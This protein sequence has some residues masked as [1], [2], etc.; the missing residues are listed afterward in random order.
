M[1][2]PT[3]EAPRRTR[4]KRGQG[5]Q[6]REQILDATYELLVETGNA[7]KV[8]TR[9]VAQRVGCSSPAL[10]LHFPDKASL[11]WATCNRQFLRLSELIA[12]AVAGLDDPVEALVAAGRAYVTFGVEHLEEY[13]VMMMVPDMVIWNPPIGEL[14]NE[15][16][17]DIL[18]ALIER[19]M[20]AGRIRDDDPTMVALTVWAA[21]H[22]IVSLRVA[23]PAFEWPPID[24]QIDRMLDLVTTGL[25]AGA[26]DAAPARGGRR[27]PRSRRSADRSTR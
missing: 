3:T 24:D 4:A 10:Y 9:A 6:L 2:A 5:D 15:A 19:A 13:R 12:A 20:A 27:R 18:H 21:M 23:K 22:G 17:F 8:S 11:L 16:G 26:D 25:A 14:P 1:A 7:D